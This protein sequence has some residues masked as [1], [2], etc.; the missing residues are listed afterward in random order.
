MAADMAHNVTSGTCRFDRRNEPRRR[1][2][3]H[4]RGLQRGVASLRRSALSAGPRPQKVLLGTGCSEV[5]CSG[6]AEVALLALCSLYFMTAEM[7][8]YDS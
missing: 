2:A 6:S 8:S 1:G 3:R 5:F 4:G 7:I